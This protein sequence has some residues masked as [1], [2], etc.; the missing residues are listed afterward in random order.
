MRQRKGM[1]R[2]GSIP[3]FGYLHNENMERVVN[4]ETASTVR[5][6]FNLYLK[7]YTYNEI[8]NYLYDNKIITP[9]F[10]AF[11][12]FNYNAKNWVDV[13]ND[14]KYTWSKGVIN[15]ILEEQQYTG[16][17]ILKR[18]QTVSY[19]THKRIKTKKDD[20][21]IFENKFPGII[22]KE[23]FCLVKIKM[24][25]KTKPL[26]PVEENAY[27]DF[28]FCGNCGHALSL[29]RTKAYPEYRMKAY[30]I[31]KC[32]NKKPCDS[33]INIRY[34]IV[35]ETV[36][37]ELKNII[38]VLIANEKSIKEYAKTYFKK[39]NE[40][41]TTEQKRYDELIVRNK[42]LELLMQKLFEK[43]AIGDIPD[44]TYKKM[45]EG[46]KNELQKNIEE[47]NTINYLNEMQQ[48]KD[49]VYL[50]NGFYDSLHNVLDSTNIREILNAVIW[51]IMIYKNG[52]KYRLKFIYQNIPEMLEDYF[53]WK[54]QQN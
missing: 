12:T 52:K 46:Y 40:L 16:D 37:K 5:I 49:Y 43:N 19:K 38:V 7:N 22:T 2:K 44:D 34:E 10:Y 27:K 31:Y 42:K 20:L 50:T 53:K 1:L 18:K 9:E 25:T 35:D 28:I 24:R 30:N 15:K 47:I 45:N 39:D 51:K 26:I 17:L 54:K 6:I 4:E 23:Q 21:L 13:S 33:R 36:K 3:L 41:L 48:K 11:V 32:R 8:S 29:N 14:K